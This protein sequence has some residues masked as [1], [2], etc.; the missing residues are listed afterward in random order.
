ML[1]DDNLFSVIGEK[2]SEFT[3]AFM[4]DEDDEVFSRFDRYF[5]ESND[6]LHDLIENH[7]GNEDK[8]IIESDSK[9]I[10][11]EEVD[12]VPLIAEELPAEM[13]TE[14]SVESVQ[15]ENDVT[16]IEETQD[17]QAITNDWITSLSTMDYFELNEFSQQYRWYRVPTPDHTEE[18]RNLTNKFKVFCK[19][20]DK[21]NDWVIMNGLLTERYSVASL[22]GFTDALCSTL[23]IE[24]EN[25]I[26][27]L[28]YFRS[29]W[30]KDLDSPVEVFEDDTAKMI[31][32]LISGTPIEHLDEVSTRLSLMVVNS[33][34]GKT[35]LG[36]DYEL[37]TTANVNSASTT[38]RDYFT[39]SRY[40]TEV[41]HG[42]QLINISSDIGNIIENLNNT[43]DHL[44]AIELTSR[45]I[46]SIG[47]CFNKES[48]STFLDICTNMTPDFRN[49]FHVSIVASIVLDHRFNI[50]SYLRM[51]TVIG[52][53]NH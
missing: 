3:S 12:S 18:N 6:S 2:D 5:E 19:W 51:R 21:S 1:E 22:K 30:L 48:K 41:I 15:I 53:L 46:E 27:H 36:I 11:I 14:A 17:T 20:P 4:E 39:L 43:V 24:N 34:N 52:S 50:D 32:A 28:G 38:F 40:S 8:I 29:L 25:Y 13:T 9:E 16:T 44:K 42:N 26:T 23:G 33:Y 49:L 7:E 31:F 35:K 10:K 47:S 45:E 37:K